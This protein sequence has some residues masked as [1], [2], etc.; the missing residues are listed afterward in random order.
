MSVLSDEVLA[1][2]REYAAVGDI[3]GLMRWVSDNAAAFYSEGELRKTFSMP[4]LVGDAPRAV[5]LFDKL[6]IGY[7]PEAERAKRRRVVRGSFG[8]FALILLGVLGGVAYLVM[9]IVGALR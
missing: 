7:D 9:L 1:I 2:G 8:C 5:K 6:F 4:I 3:D